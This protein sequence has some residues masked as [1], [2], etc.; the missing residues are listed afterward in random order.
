MCSHP[1]SS[2]MQDD[3]DRALAR[4]MLIQTRAN[5]DA[6]LVEIIQGLNDLAE[7]GPSSYGYRK[8]SELY[9]WVL[10]PLR[11]EDFDAAWSGIIRFIEDPI[12]ARIM[13]RLLRHV[14]PSI[15]VLALAKADFDL[16]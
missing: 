16:S 2:S 7:A 13:T 5:C 4:A 12:M 3:I 11:N 15:A 9:N 14:E 8:S 6:M 10:E 1:A